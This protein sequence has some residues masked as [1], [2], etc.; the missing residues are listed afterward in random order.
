MSDYV[1]NYF[2][3]RNKINRKNY[4]FSIIFL[5]V[6]LLLGCIVFLRPINFKTHELFFVQVGECQVYSDAINLSKEVSK[7]GDAGYIYFDK[8]YHVLTSFHSSKK[9][10]KSTLKNLKTT[11]KNLSIFTIEKNRFSY[12]KSLTK[13]QN[14]TLENFI[15]DTEKISL[16][17]EQFCSSFFKN[18]LDLNTFSIHIQNLKTDY[19]NVCDE[20][21]NSFNKN[22]KFNAAKKHTNSMLNS[23]TNLTENMEQKST[24]LINNQII[25]FVIHRHQFLSCF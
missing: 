24:S 6:I 3:Y 5:W 23:L 8:N 9:D 19:E 22:P 13:S 4:N 17:L 20:L 7:N 18:C 10:A 21:L 25:N 15:N 14:K 11:Y 2:Q 12:Q 16:K 1:F